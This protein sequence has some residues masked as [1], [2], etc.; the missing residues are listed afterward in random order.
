MNRQ[1][2]QYL[3]AR[4]ILG[5][6]LLAIVFSAFLFAILIITSAGVLTSLM[7]A[8]VG[9]VV[10]AL[11]QYWFWGHALLEN[12]AQ[13]REQTEAHVRQERE[14]ARPVDKLTLVLNEEERVE[15][16]H[17]L[18]QSLAESPAAVPSRSSVKKEALRGLLDKLRGF[19]A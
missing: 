10:F 2:S 18:E 7:T 14:A 9:L 17:T 12:V 8:T 13:Q 4:P 1:P 19:G 16:M 6:I 15:L 11:V 3:R 5:D